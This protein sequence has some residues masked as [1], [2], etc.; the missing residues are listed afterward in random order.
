MTMP[1]SLRA[2]STSAP[3]REDGGRDACTEDGGPPRQLSA[4]L[5]SA[6]SFLFNS[7]ALFMTDACTESDGRP[8]QSSAEVR[9]LSEDP[10]A[11]SARAW[12]RSPRSGLS[13]LQRNSYPY[14]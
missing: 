10:A 11:L 14:C 6:P 3:E 8:R 4:A 1:C 9:D 2:A 5:R 12:L 13:T 7:L